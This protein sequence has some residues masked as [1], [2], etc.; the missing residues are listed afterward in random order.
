[1]TDRAIL[2]ED[3]KGRLLYEYLKIF[4]GYAMKVGPIG[5]SEQVGGNVNETSLVDWTSLTRPGIHQDLLVQ[6]LR[7]GLRPGEAV[8]KW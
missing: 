4:H 5:Q 8:A 2:G 6:G 1:M 7:S 3:S